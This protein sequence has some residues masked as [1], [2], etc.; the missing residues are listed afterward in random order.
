MVDL[1]ENVAL[2][3]RGLLTGHMDGPALRRKCSDV[4]G[5]NLCHVCDPHSDMAIF[6][7]QAIL[8]SPPSSRSLLTVF[9]TAAQLASGSPSPHPSSDFT[10][11]MAQAMDTA[12]ASAKEKLH[13]LDAPP[14]DNF[15]SDPFTPSMADAM[16]VIERSW[17]NDNGS[18]S[19]S[20]KSNPVTPDHPR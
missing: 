13:L 15:S 8:R 6:A 20:G 17:T 4:A 16:D 18:S 7:R 5:C 10:P 1:Q 3:S 9:T 12:E 11:A 14:S 19:T 2:C